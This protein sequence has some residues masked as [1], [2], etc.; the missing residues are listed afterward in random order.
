MVCS[1][2]ACCKAGR[3]WAAHLQRRGVL[4]RRWPRRTPNPTLTPTLTPTPTPNPQPPTQSLTPTLTQPLTPTPTPNSN[5]NL[6]SKQVAS[7]DAVQTAGSPLTYSVQ[8]TDRQDVLVV[9]EVA[10]TLQGPLLRGLAARAPVGL[11]GVRTGLP[12]TLRGKVRLRPDAPEPEPEP[13]PESEPEH[14]PEPEPGAAAPRRPDRP[15]AG[16]VGAG[17]QGQ[18]AAAP[19]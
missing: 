17:A 7:E 19:A 8:V 13:E 9:W 18:R 15:R 2:S 10:A 11:P 16:G 5:P 1:A 12:V 14:E 6:N 4:T 3:R